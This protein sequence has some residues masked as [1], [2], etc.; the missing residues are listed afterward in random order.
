MLLYKVIVL[1][2]ERAL[3]ERQRQIFTVSGAEIV[4][5]PCNHTIYASLPRKSYGACGPRRNLLTIFLTSQCI[6]KIC[7]IIERLPENDHMGIVQ[8]I[9]QNVY[10]LWLT[11]F[12]NLFNFQ[13]EQSGRGHC[14]QTPPHGKVHV[15]SWP[16]CRLR[17]DI[18][19]K[20]KL[21]FSFY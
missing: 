13:T 11:M 5:I 12:E 18:T 10:R 19:T 1:F 21:G 16:G 8:Y 20:C 7:P 9:L 4:R 14:M 15:D 17:R 3:G 6:Q 2:L